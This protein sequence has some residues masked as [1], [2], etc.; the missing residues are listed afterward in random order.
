[1]NSKS[2]QLHRIIRH[3]LVRTR[4]VGTSKRP[5]VSIFRSNKNVFVQFIDDSSGKTLLSSKVVSTAT[6]KIR[7]NKI[8]K[9]LEIGKMLAEK[10]KE[11]GIVEAVFDRGGYRYHGRIKSVAD[12]MR[13]GGLKF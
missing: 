4:I 7:G 1:M 3:K 11:A 2:K 6:S 9:S 12:G 10:A 8:Y 13:A 5:R